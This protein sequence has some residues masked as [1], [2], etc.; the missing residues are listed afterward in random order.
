MHYMIS[1]YKSVCMCM[2]EVLRFYS[3]ELI[4]CKNYSWKCFFMK[5]LEH[6]LK[7][8]LV[9][10]PGPHSSIAIFLHN[11]TEILLTYELIACRIMEFVLKR[12]TLEVSEFDPWWDPLWD[13]VRC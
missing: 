1:K 6:M 12:E 8:V 11:K 2:S 5:E 3:H 13:R 10:L 9:K 4:L 7:F